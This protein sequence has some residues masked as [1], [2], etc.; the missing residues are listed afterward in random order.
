M[1]QVIRE[2]LKWRKK[3]DDLCTCCG[4]CCYSRSLSKDGRVL[5][6]YFRP[7]ENLDLETNL[8]RIYPNRLELCDHCDKVTLRIAMFHPTLPEDCPYRIHFRPWEQKKKRNRRKKTKG[9]R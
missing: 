5:I 6:H 2:W 8:C 9:K 1:F 4:K 3:W 7:C